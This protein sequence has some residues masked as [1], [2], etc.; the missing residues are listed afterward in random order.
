MH[1]APFAAA[2]GLGLVFNSTALAQSATSFTYQGHLAESGEPAEGMYEFEIRLLDDMG[3]QIGGVAT[4]VAMVSEG[5]FTVDLDFGPGVFD[6][7]PRM[8]EIGVRDMM[9]GG[10]FAV[11][12]PNTP[13]SSAPVA[14]FALAGN[15]GPQ[16]PQGADGPQGPIGPVGPQGP[17]GDTGP[18]GP[19]GP[20]GDPGPTGPQGPEGPQG[21]QG[22]VGPPG[23]TSWTGLDDIP[24][25]IADGDDDTTY[26]AGDGLLLSGT[27]FSIPAD[28]IDDA[29]LAP[30][31]VGPVE[32]E[33]NHL[34]LARVSGNAISRDAD[35]NVFLDTFATLNIGA[36]TPAATK[37]QIV[38]GSDST[39]TDG[40][41]L[42]I[43]PIAGQNLSLD[44]NEIMARNN[45]APARLIVN[46]EG[47]DINLGNTTDD[48]SVGIGLISPSDRLHINTAP[49][50]S[51]LRVQQDGLTR[52]RINANGG[53]S[54]GSNNTTVADSN[55]YMPESLGIR[56]STP[57]NLLHIA[58]PTTLDHGL[59]L[60]SGSA[61]TLLAPS[62]IQ[63]NGGFKLETALS[64]TIQ[65]GTHFLVE[66][67]GLID[68]E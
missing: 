50:Q 38:G 9:S 41:Y 27:M 51:A 52:L 11:L 7:S 12:S 20:Q 68:F 33:L 6:G 25:D 46:G 2:I 15:E 4:P 49:G 43:G 26:T 35:G 48:G 36:E 39:A 21:P 65:T 62:R 44:D 10:A 30:N 5:R 40:G 64:H 31:S 56:V 17:Q 14:Q 59:L 34:S 37:L 55:V 66:A 8:L 42:T 18:Q 61:S 32:L 53:I 45:G 1:L 24:G 16:G 29:L 67:D 63:A 60:T 57:E 23:T 47:G 22:P 19:I 13:I 3:V 28:G 58:S 54:I